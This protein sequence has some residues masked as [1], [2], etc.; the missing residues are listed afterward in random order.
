VRN[1]KAVNLLFDFMRESNQKVSRAKDRSPAHV[2]D[3]RVAEFALS[4]LDTFGYF[5]EALGSWKDITLADIVKAIGQFQALFGL[6]KT[7]MLD[8]KTVRTMEM[9]R[10]GCPDI[11]R[12]HHTEACG[13][14]N[15]VNR[16]LPK[17][18]KSGVTYAITDYMPS[19]SKSVMDEVVSKAFAAWT[20]HGNIE[21]TQ[22]TSGTPDILISYGR[23][24][25]SNFDGPGGT[26]AWAYLPNGS[27]S[28]LLC[29]FDVDET[30]ILDPAAR[31]ILLFNVACH[32]FGHLLGL[33][34]SRVQSALMAPYYNPSVAVPAANDDIPRFQARYGQKIGP[35]A[36]P[37][38]PPVPVP[39]SEN[40]SLTVTASG[41]ITELVANGKKFI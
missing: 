6:V 18:R 11:L 5:A 2:A 14:R 10:C 20:R 25:Q 22:S 37:P 24:R 1:A 3:R 7:K 33:D 29:R 34:H 39:P 4:Y 38:P 12:E 13:L 9:P 40:S 26:L 28:Q 35:P 17:W 31:G 21:V 27:D 30:W 36:S 19:V 15:V 41:R 8:V 23:G 16:N 32:E